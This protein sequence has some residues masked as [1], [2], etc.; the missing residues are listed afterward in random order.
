MEKLLTV[1]LYENERKY[2]TCIFV[3]HIICFRSFVCLCNTFCCLCSD[4][5]YTHTA[6]LPKHVWRRS[7]GVLHPVETYEGVVSQ[8]GGHSGL[9]PRDHCNASQ[10]ASFHQG[11]QLIWSFWVRL[12]ADCCTVHWWLP[13]WL[14]SLS[15]CFIV[16]CHDA[17]IIVTLWSAPTAFPCQ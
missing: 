14:G 16:N 17:F 5:S 12:T 13:S 9:W 8:H 2:V 11:A 3:C 7:V 10:P 6:L 4:R 15:S 1:F